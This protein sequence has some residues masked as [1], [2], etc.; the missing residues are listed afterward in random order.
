VKKILVIGSGGAGKSTFSR[1]FG[2]ITGIE[3]IHLDKIYWLPNWTE[4]SKAEFEK[5]LKPELEKPRWIMDGNF[6]GTLE[7]RIEKCDTVIS[8]ELPR[9]ICLY[10]ALK[11]IFKYRGTKRPDMGEGCNENFDLEFLMWIW[12]FPKKDKL[13]IEKALG[14]FNGKVKIIRL[15]SKKE[16]ENFFAEL[17]SN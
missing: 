15:K 13:K 2:E 14:K 1:R 3:V 17:R 16:V 6:K 9:T 7:M 4:P 5:I 10:R 12:N 8:F 11:R